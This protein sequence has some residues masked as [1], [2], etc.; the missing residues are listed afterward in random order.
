VRAIASICCS[1]PDNRHAIRYR[2]GSNSG[3]DWFRSGD[4][5]Y[6]DHEGFLYLTDRKKDM[7]IRETRP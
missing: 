7:I 4:V 5:G 6:L 2:D 3:N 1:P